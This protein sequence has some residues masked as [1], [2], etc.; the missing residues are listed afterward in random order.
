SHVSRVPAYQPA[1][2]MHAAPAATNANHLPCADFWKVRRCCSVHEGASVLT[3]HAVAVATRSRM[4]LL[5]IPCAAG[6]CA[7]SPRALKQYTATMR[8]FISTSAAASGGR[9][10]D[11]APQRFV[12]ITG[13]FL[14]VPPLVQ[15]RDARRG[16]RTLQRLQPR[17][18]ITAIYLS[19][20][21]RRALLRCDTPLGQ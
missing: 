7:Q 11:G 9:D 5:I 2:Q 15:R 1:A 18:G 16:D 14:R 20:D 10:R 3:S 12:P 21:C 8:S 17:Q 13:T 19:A 4:W 6:F